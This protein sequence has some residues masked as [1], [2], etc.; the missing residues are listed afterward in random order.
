[1][2]FDTLRPRLINIAAPV[3]EHPRSGDLR[4]HP[5]PPAAP[6]HLKT[7]A[8]CPADLPQPSTPS[9]YPI[10]T[11]KPAA[12]GSTPYPGPDQLQLKSECRHLRYANV[13]FSCIDQASSN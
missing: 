9:T 2:Q 8:W 5:Q 12:A 1:M 3:V 6:G 13:L 11:N 4:H 10:Q 7:G